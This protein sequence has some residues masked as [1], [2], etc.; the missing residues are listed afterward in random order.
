MAVTHSLSH[1]LSEPFVSCSPSGFLATAVQGGKDRKDRDVL[2]SQK[3]LDEL[4]RHWHWLR[5]KPSVWLFPGKRRYTS[6]RP[7]TS[8]L[9]YHACTRAARR[10]ALQK[11]VHPHTLPAYSV[12]HFNSGGESVE[13]DAANFGATPCIKTFRKPRRNNSVVSVA[14]LTRLRRFVAPSLNGFAITL[15]GHLLSFSL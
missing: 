13:N 8:K 3:L 11:G 4:R 14:V 15:L 10:A 9:I 2:L 7:I 5:R 12:R 1:K 6:D